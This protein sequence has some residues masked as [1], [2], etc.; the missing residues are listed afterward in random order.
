MNVHPAKLEVRLSK[1]DAL[2]EIITTSIKEALTKE[3]LIPEP[4]K[5]NKAKPA[6]SEQLAF[7]LAYEAQQANDVVRE[8]EQPRPQP[9][10]TQ[11]SFMQR[12][13]QAYKQVQDSPHD[14]DRTQDVSQS[15]EL[16][17][18]K[19][20]VQT[21]PEME[22][23]VQ[24]VEHRAENI[25]Q[26]NKEEAS[27]VPPLYPVGQ[28]HG[29]YII[30]QN[31]NGMYLID[32]HAAQERIKY[33]YFHKKLAEPLAQTQELI[34]P[35]TLE[36]TTREALL[37]NESK[38][39]LEAVGLFLEEFGK[40]TFMVRSHPTWF[41]SGEEEST[42]R[43]MFEQLLEMRTINVQDLREEAAI[44]MSCKAAIKRIVIYAMMRSFN[45]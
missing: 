5:T 42:I 15:A 35:I 41:P 44:L 25:A 3:T 28:M 6:E 24:E 17:K 34:V 19:K 27:S 7:S 14:T 2:A 40:N 45:C 29:T 16:L 23:P 11:R 36:L 33:E 32:Q 26:T 21:E 4:T 20:E 30:A 39:K 22:A 18:I 43:E 31:E 38:E 13:E 1:E 10:E 12:E 8:R 9:Q 37:I